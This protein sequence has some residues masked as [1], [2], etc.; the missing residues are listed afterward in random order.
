M[1]IKN[2]LHLITAFLLVISSCNKAPKEQI[3]FSST[4][5]DN[6][7]SYDALGTPINMLKD[8]ISPGLLSFINTTLPDGLNLTK[9]H[10]ELFTST[11]NNDI[12]I[13]QHSDV[14]V[15]FITEGTDGRNSIA[16]Y[17]YPTSTPP[18]SS[19][20]IAKITYIFPSAGANTALKAGDKLKL[21]TFEPGTSI[22]FVLMV[23]A[24]DPSSRKLNNNSLHFCS[25]DILNPE[26]DP[27]LKKHA[28]F[29]NYSTEKKTLVGFEDQDRSNPSCDNDFNDVIFYVSVL[30]Q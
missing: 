10:P 13:T 9:S 23:N 22:G 12:V 24:W 2:N 19:K 21:G 28:V 15:T 5:Y 1:K 16:Y 11:A 30:Q 3:T 20:D 18:E 4:T 6:L 17:S 26:V 27:T 8:T 7:S 29:I 14:Y 25:D